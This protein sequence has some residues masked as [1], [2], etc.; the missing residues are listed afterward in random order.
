MIDIPKQDPISYEESAYDLE[1]YDFVRDVHVNV[2]T[3]DVG[4]VTKLEV[5]VCTNSL[6]SFSDIVLPV[7][8]KN[9]EEFD[10]LLEGKLK[11]ADEHFKKENERLEASFRQCR[12]FN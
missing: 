5:M 7:E 1:G 4:Y 9:K 10:Q 2:C 3:N 12:L 11:Q 8:F 6:E